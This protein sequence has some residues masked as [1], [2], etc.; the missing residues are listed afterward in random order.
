MR[1]HGLLWKEI[2]FVN[3]KKIKYIA[4]RI[5]SVVGVKANR[6]LTTRMGC[7]VYSCTYS[8]SS[9]PRVSSRKMRT[10]NKVVMRNTLLT[11]KKRT[12]KQ[13]IKEAIDNHRTKTIWQRLAL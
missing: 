8:P 13:A 2:F 5:Q 4:K 7:E 1:I 11:R 9:L 3:R 10:M 12:K 6:K